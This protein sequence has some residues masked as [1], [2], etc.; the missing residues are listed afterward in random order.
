MKATYTRKYYAED[1]FIPY[2]DWQLDEIATL[3]ERKVR[4]LNP[5][6]GT[7]SLL[8]TERGERRVKILEAKVIQGAFVPTIVQPS[9]KRPMS[10]SSFLLGNKLTT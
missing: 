3:F 10:W 1:A 7:Y 2:K 9:G 5:E 6:P 4:A 8:P